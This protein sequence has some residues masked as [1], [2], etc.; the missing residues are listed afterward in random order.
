MSINSAT[1]IGYKVAG[2]PGS[3]ITTLGI[4]LPSF[5]VISI[6]F[7]SIHKFK[8]SPY[9]DWVFRGIR[10][11]AF[12]LIATAAVTIGKVSLVDIKSI[13]IALLLFY[14]VSFKKLNPILSIILAGG[15]G[16]IL[17]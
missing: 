11:V 5:I 7:R 16:V 1:F 2:V 8:D 12:G 6:I 13:M 17:Y 15:L 4:V 10:P 9:V 14:V 3:I